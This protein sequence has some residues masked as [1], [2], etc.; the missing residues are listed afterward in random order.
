MKPGADQPGTAQA[1]LD[2]DALAVSDRFRLFNFTRRDDHLAYLWVL[3]ALERLRA[4]HHDPGAPGRRRPRPGGARRALR[5]RSRRS[6][7]SPRC[8]A[9]STPS[10]TTRSCTGLRTPPG[11]AASPGTGTGSRSTSSASSATARTPPSRTCCAPASGTPTCPASSSPTS[12]RTC[13][14]CTPRPRRGRRPGVPQALAPGHRARRHVPPRRPVPPDAR[15]DHAVHRHLAR[16]VHE[17]QERP[18][19]PHDRLHGRA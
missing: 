14:R 8:A 11:P 9:A 3:R 4:V 15:R 2:L 1:S 17:V 18:A 19:H 16:D 7:T 6:M 12:S 13:A 5:R 10:P